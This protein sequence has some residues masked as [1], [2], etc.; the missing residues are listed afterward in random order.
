MGNE[1]SA[2]A[3]AGGGPEPVDVESGGGR[4]VENGED[5]AGATEETT[6]TRAEALQLATE[7][8]ELARTDPNDWEALAGEYSDDPGGNG[9]DLGN[10]GRGQM[11]PAF[12]RA[13]FALRIGEI[14]DPVESPFGFH[15]IQRYE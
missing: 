13:A 14:S 4:G 11:V 7:V 8:A 6:R 12:E 3:A 9:G 15:V 10:F 5:E 1:A 2:A